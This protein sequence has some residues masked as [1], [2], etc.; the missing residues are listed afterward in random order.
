MLFG[1]RHSS[2][3]APNAAAAALAAGVAWLSWGRRYSHTDLL[4]KIR[5]DTAHWPGS[6]GPAW[7]GDLVLNSFKSRQVVRALGD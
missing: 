5:L 7:K 2:Q 6:C 4:E 1:I 3:K